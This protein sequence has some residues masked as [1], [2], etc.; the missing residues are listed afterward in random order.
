M[1]VSW[2]QILLGAGARAAGAAADWHAHRHWPSSREEAEPIQ[3]RL[4]GP[5]I[6]KTIGIYPDG[7]G[8]ALRLECG[9]AA[10]KFRAGGEGLGDRLTEIRLNIDEVNQLQLDA[11]MA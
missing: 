4:E 1:N 6:V 10:A 8:G 7:D 9:D 11:A 5:K 3:L 2:Q